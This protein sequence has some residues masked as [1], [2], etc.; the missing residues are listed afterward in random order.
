MTCLPTD[1]AT[2]LDPFWTAV[3]LRLLER[4]TGHSVAMPDELGAAVGRAGTVRAIPYSRFTEFSP[5]DAF[6]LHK[7]MTELFSAA[8][9]ASLADTPIV[10]AN[11]VF[12]V[13]SEHLALG[14]DVAA[15][16]HHAQSFFEHL[17]QRRNAPR[18]DRRLAF[19]HLPKTAG[20]SLVAALDQVFDERIYFHDWMG[21]DDFR[22]RHDDYDFIAGHVFVHQMLQDVDDDR[23]IFVLLRDPAERFLS[24][25]AH[26]R[27]PSEDF[28]ALSD[29]MKAMRRM[30]VDAFLA[31]D[32]A[33]HELHMQIDLLSP[34]PSIRG[35]ASLDLAG[36]LETLRHPRVVAGVVEEM[37]VFLAL[38][39]NHLPGALPDLQFLNATS[40]KAG[41]ISEAERAAVKRMDLRRSEI[42]HRAARDEARRRLAAAG[43][44]TGVTWNPAPRWMPQLMT[45]IHAYSQ[46]SAPWPTRTVRSKGR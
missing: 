10:F 17:A 1:Q 45:R 24:A 2:R 7:G 38:L 36:A 29:S 12:L 35:S 13:F 44:S 11:E 26:A 8:F 34:V 15:T 27:R 33:E 31:L 19:C 6:V 5:C 41:L 14:E 16:M 46:R 4:S 25:V 21:F 32:F 39:R 23:P 30:P 42:L 37:D 18:P 3:A 43:A 28:D 40:G 22:G 20:T 9:L